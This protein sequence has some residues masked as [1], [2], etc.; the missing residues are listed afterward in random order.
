MSKIIPFFILGVILVACGG[1]TP[2]DAPTTEGTD[3]GVLE[4]QETEE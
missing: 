2:T 1:S 3:S 4:S